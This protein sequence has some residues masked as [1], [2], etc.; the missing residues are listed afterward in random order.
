MLVQAGGG[1]AG[2]VLGGVAFGAAGLVIGKAVGPRND[3]G[4]TLVGGVL[5]LAVG[6]VTGV[7]VGVQ[8][9]GDARDGTGRWW[10]TAAGTLVA[11]GG[12]IAI[13]LATQSSA[14]FVKT[15]AV[16]FVVLVLAT[17]IVGYHVSADA[18]APMAVPLTL[19]F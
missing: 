8:L 4:A 6:F 19:R 7:G 9:S 3:W 17:S 2:G 18:H 15:K 12:G 11:T 14:G 1:V 16:G 13:A 10:G 5:G